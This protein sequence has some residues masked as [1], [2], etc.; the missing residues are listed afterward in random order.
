MPGAILLQ[1][2]RIDGVATQAAALLHLT[3]GTECPQLLRVL[4][5]MRH[6]RDIHAS[7]AL[8]RKAAPNIATL[9]IATWDLVRCPCGPAS[10]A[11]TVATWGVAEQCPMLVAADDAS[12]SGLRRLGSPLQLHTT[13]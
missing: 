5:Q 13:F 7:L 8:W 1:M 2:R 4:L 12:R 9:G 6:K 10:F 3:P 11:S